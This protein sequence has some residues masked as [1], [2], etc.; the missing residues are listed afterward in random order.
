M[1]P[2]AE[3]YMYRSGLRRMRRRLNALHRRPSAVGI[4]QAALDLALGVAAA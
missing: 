3:R 1:R 4:A 2:T